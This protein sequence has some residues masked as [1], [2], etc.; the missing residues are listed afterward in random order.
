MG[1]LPMTQKKAM[2]VHHEAQKSSSTTLDRKLR[3]STRQLDS[4]R[5]S[6]LLEISGVTSFGRCKRE[7]ISQS[8]AFNC[9]PA[10]CHWIWRTITSKHPSL[11]IR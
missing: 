1:I 3:A 10:Y 5:H 11:G 6:R 8:T 7:K 4:T 9:F 2:N